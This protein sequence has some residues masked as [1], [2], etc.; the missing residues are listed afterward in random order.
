M[1]TAATGRP[2]KVQPAPKTLRTNCL[3]AGKPGLEFRDSAARLDAGLREMNAPRPGSWFSISGNK[4]EPI[5]GKHAAAL[6][7]LLFS[8]WEERFLQAHA[9]APSIESK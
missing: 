1:P 9:G 4:G 6:R 7:D 3:K 8:W 5:A 2:I